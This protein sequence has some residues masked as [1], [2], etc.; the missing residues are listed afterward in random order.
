MITEV[1]RL[2]QVLVE[3]HKDLK[4]VSTHVASLRSKLIMSL[5]SSCGISLDES[6]DVVRALE[7][8]HRDLRTIAHLL[9]DMKPEMTPST[10]FLL[11]PIQVEIGKA[12]G[13]L[14]PD[15]GLHVTNEANDPPRYS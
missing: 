11:A 1:N 4:K 9:Q 5:F 15:L 10:E 13:V 6:E 2:Y 12:A 14:H 8:D 7:Y 3:K